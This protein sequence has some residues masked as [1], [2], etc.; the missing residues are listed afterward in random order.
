VKTRAQNTGLLLFCLALLGI[1][2]FVFRSERSPD[3]ALLPAGAPGESIDPL[4][5][6]GL[7]ATAVSGPSSP[8]DLQPFTLRGGGLRSLPVISHP[9]PKLDGPRLPEMPKAGDDAAFPLM[10]P[11][12]EALDLQ[13]HP[14]LR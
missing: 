10:D 12:P 3:L 6:A 2:A 14:E 1:A 9:L 11:T 13:L 4:P 5:S 8:A 7:E